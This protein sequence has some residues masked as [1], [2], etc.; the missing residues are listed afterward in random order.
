LTEASGLK[1]TTVDFSLRSSLYIFDNFM[2]S[3]HSVTKTK[4]RSSAVAETA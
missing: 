3:K 4:T 1:A 2:P